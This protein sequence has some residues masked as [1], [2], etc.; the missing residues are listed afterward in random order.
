[1]CRFC[2]VREKV[3]LE[4][5]LNACGCVAHE[6]CGMDLADIDSILFHFFD[7]FS[8]LVVFRSHFHFLHTLPLDFPLVLSCLVATKLTLWAREAKLAPNETLHFKTFAPR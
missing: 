3:R 1:M 6:R 2:R 8:R 5:R 4:F 7:A